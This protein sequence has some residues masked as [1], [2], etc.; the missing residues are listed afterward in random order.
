MTE[1]SGVWIDKGTGLRCRARYDAWASGAP[2]L[3][4]VKTAS[5]ITPDGFARSVATYGYHR[6]QAHY[7]AGFRALTG[8]APEMFLFAAVSSAAPFVAVPY[9]LDAEAVAQGEAEIRHLLELFARCKESNRWPGPG[10]SGIQTIGL[11]R[12][13][14]PQE[15]MEVSYDD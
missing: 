1:V 3:V 13:A 7:S 5:D 12:W 9:L 8:Q 14:L 15:E 6:Q 4:D 11:P 2:I 10:D